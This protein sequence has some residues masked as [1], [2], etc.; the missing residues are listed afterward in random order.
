MHSGATVTEIVVE[1][2]GHTSRASAMAYV[3]D[4]VVFVGSCLGDSKVC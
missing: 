2:L 4:G 3:D 1:S